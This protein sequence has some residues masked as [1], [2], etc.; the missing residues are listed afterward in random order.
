MANAIELE[1]GAF[2]WRILPELLH[3]D[4]HGSAAKLFHVTGPPL[5][6]W[7][8][9]GQA[10]IVKHGP[11]RTVY[12]VMLPGLDFHLK[13]YRLADTRAWLRELVRPSKAR[14][15]WERTLAVAERGVPTIAPLAFGEASEQANSTCSFLATRTLPEAAPLNVFL[16]TTLP[17]FPYHRQTRMRQR[18][19]VALGELIACMHDAGVTQHDLHPGNV[20]LRFAEADAPQLFLIDLYAVEIGEPPSWE[21]S[22][23]NLVVFNRWFMLRSERSDRL[24][25]WR[26][27][28]CSRRRLGGTEW[29]GTQSDNPSSEQRVA[30]RDLER[31]SLASNLRFWRTLDKRCL[32]TNRYFREVCQGDVVGHVVA[33]LP[34]EIVK[35][36]FDDPDEPFRRADVQVLKQ[37][38]SSTVITLELPGE[39]GPLRLVYKRFAVTHWSDPLVALVRRTPALRSYVLGHGLRLRCLPTPRPLGVWQRYKYGLPQEGY[40]L[41][42][43]VPDAIDLHQYVK[44][45]LSI[46]T[47]RSQ[48]H[49][50]TL[51]DQ[52]AR[53]IG[54]L[55]YRQIS[56]RDLK[57]SNVL[58]S[59]DQLSFVDLVGVM[60]HRKLRRSRR[61]QNLAR[62]NASSMCLAGLTRTDKL[63]FL[64]A[65]L[66]W[67]LQGRHGW[68]RWWHEIE[69]AT[70]EK[71][72][73][74]RRNG[75]PLG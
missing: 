16:E 60:R 54:T 29:F 11:H 43:W 49:L 30:A 48:L 44:Q 26:A 33:D 39:N 20:L 68:K 9:A 12:R 5:D 52:L 58:V 57:A 17:Q 36:F 61:I 66:H 7:Q 27:Y 37:S 8:A 4:A 63:R 6:E 22:R 3:N 25:F 64:R 41:T 71:T 19:A 69:K 24:R 70:V 74:N 47:K 53:L 55:H 65:Y 18:L 31:R 73:R 46:G 14:L 23:A 40:L 75:R 34:K 13:Q 10:R 59:G 72:E 21:A 28:H 42:E 38:P 50:R 35:R 1:A 2:H 62:L 51:I 15:E 45:L 56:H 32:G 67:G